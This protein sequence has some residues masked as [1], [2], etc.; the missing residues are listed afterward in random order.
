MT[1]MRYVRISIFRALILYAANAA[2]QASTPASQP[3]GTNLPGPSQPVGTVQVPA[4]ANRPLA[5]ICGEFGICLSPKKKPIAVPQGGQPCP[6]PASATA[7]APSPAAVPPAL[8]LNHGPLSV[9][10]GSIFSYAA[11]AHTSVPTCQ[12]VN[13]QMGGF[14]RCRK[15][16]FHPACK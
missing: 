2:G 10:T 12:F 13:F 5:K 8:R 9:R 4:S 6:P 11:T 14:C 16:R 3:C 15:F 1:K 7:P